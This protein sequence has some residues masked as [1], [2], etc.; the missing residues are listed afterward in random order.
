M[1]HR[2]H[3]LRLGARQHPLPISISQLLIRHVLLLAAAWLS[4]HR[5]PSESRHATAETIRPAVRIFLV[6]LSADGDAATNQ[7]LIESS[8]YWS[9]P[10]ML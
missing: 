5:I 7:V 1:P 3:K 2:R 8:Q 6:R 9:M 10:P 4:F